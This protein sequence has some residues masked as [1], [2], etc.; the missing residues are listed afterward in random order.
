MKLFRLTLRLRIFLSMILIIILSFLVTG[1]ISYYHYKK[2]NEQ[3]HRA[4]LQRKQETVMEA[5]DYFLSD[6]KLGT[7]SD[8]IV[9]VFNDKICELADIN[10]MDINLY[11]ME[12]NLLISSTPQLHEINIVPDRI[13]HVLMRQLREGEEQVIVKQ[14]TDSISYLSTYSY[15]HNSAGKP[16]SIVNLPYFDVDD[17]HREDLRDF[18]IRLSQIYFILFLTATLLAYLLSNY[19]TSSLNTIAERIKR[20]RFSESNPRLDWSYED[21]IGT[22]VAEYNRMLEALEESARKLAKKERESAWKEMARQVAHEI[23]NPLTPMR[24]NVQYLSNQLKTDEPEKLKNFRDS[25]LEQIDILSNIATAFSQF[26]NMPEMKFK[27][28]RILDV[29]E[30]VSR[31]YQ[32][33]NIVYECDEE[34]ELTADKEQLVRALNNLVNNALQAMPEGREEKIEINAYRENRQTV[35]SVRD[36]GSGIPEEMQAKIF[37]PRF[38]TKSSGMGLGLAMVKNIVDGFGGS[39]DFESIDGE[40]TIFYLRF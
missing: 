20:I 1:A 4:R 7:S 37:E 8:S 34:L 3:Y 39:I 33:R 21:E 29:V 23:K 12:G 5:I 40:G 19:I 14:Q 30:R 22:L 15:I 38:T 11:S 35:I 18:L 10:R 27:S 31:L 6:Q 2:E 36:Y 9:T 32:G 25:M 26:A 24:L 28:F 13:P 16:I 17:Y